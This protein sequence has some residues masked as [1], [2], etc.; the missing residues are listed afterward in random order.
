MLRRPQGEARARTRAGNRGRT[1]GPCRPPPRNCS[2][3]PR[4]G[5]P[6][7][8]RRPMRQAEPAADHSQGTRDDEAGAGRAA[9]FATWKQPTPKDSVLEKVGNWLNRVL[10]SAVQARAPARPGWAGYWCGDS[11]W[12]SAWAWCGGCCNWSA[13][14]ASGWCLRDHGPAAGAASASSLAAMAGRCAPRRRRR[15]VARGHSFSLLG[16]HLAPGIQ[17]PV[18]GRPRP[19][20][21]EYL[22]LVAAE[23]PRRPGLATLTGSFERVWYGGRPAG[24]SDYRGRSRLR[25]P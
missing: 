18:A 1:C 11:F 3:A 4:S 20:P 21:R 12:P 15:P 14:G 9:N 23:D 25:L 5:W 7:T 24:E 8:W 13:A 2:R 17:T 19:H 22:A 10:E 16:G 6:A